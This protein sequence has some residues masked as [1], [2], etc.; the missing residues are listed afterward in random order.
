MGRTNATYRMR[1]QQFEEEWQP[2][3]RAL[4]KQHQEPFDDLMEMADRFAAAAGMQNPVH[5]YRTILVSIALGQ[6]IERQQ[7]EERQAELEDRLDTLEA[8]ADDAI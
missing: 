7:L 4:R 5:V 8:E 3:R 6:E 1:R 2:F